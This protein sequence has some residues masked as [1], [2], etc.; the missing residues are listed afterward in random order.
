[1]DHLSQL[2]TKLQRENQELRGTLE[3]KDA[4][5]SRLQGALASVSRGANEGGIV[6][7]HPESAVLMGASRPLACKAPPLLR[8][9]PKAP[10]A[11]MPSTSTVTACTAGH[12]TMAAAWRARI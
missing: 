8:M 6:G 3:S 10:A 7:A 9:R 1:M 5:I 4:E 2:S 12:R 11:F